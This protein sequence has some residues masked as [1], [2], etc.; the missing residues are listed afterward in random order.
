MN[1]ISRLLSVTSSVKVRK[2]GQQFVKM[3]SLNIFTTK[4]VRITNKPEQTKC[5]ER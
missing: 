1:A 4:N 5:V 2:T 3:T